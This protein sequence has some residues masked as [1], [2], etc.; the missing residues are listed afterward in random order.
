MKYEISFTKAEP[1]G[2]PNKIRVSGTH[3]WEAASR[4]GAVKA[5]MD[6]FYKMWP[7]NRVRLEKVTEIIKASAPSANQ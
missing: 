2:S 6:W 4:T 5:F 3:T 1:K 7:K